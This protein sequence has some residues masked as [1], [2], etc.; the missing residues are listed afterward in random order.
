MNKRP[1]INPTDYR[2]VINWQACTPNELYLLQ[3]YGKTAEIRKRAKR[4]LFKRERVK[5]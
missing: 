4:E 3:H 1:R 2:D 5:A